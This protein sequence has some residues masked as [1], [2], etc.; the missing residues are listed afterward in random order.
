LEKTGVKPDIVSRPTSEDLAAGR[1]PVLARA[2]TLAGVPIDA[3]K[4]GAIRKELLD[5]E[6]KSDEKKKQ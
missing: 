5:A 2:A 3:Q 4:A 6:K 1:D